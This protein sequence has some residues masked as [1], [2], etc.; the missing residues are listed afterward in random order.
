MLLF[1]ATAA[2][3]QQCRWPVWQAAVATFAVL[4]TGIVGD[5]RN[6]IGVAVAADGRAHQRNPEI[7]RLV[8]LGALGAAVGGVVAGGELM[9]TAAATRRLFRVSG[10]RMRIVTA[11][12]TAS[13]RQ[14]R[15]VGM[16]VGV[17]ALTSVLGPGLHV[18]R[19]V[20]ADAALMRG[21]GSA[22]QHGLL[23]VA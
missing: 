12:A 6:V 4:M 15:M 17:T 5:L 19:C 7:V 10:A 22:P 23:L 13:A 18:V 2:T 11:H 16:D 8:A 14:L 3:A 9:A 20:T 21:D 1:V